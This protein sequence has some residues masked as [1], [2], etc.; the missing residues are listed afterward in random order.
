MLYCRLKVDQL[1]QADSLV[2]R[3]RLAILQDV[4]YHV[5]SGKIKVLHQGSFTSLWITCYDSIRVY[6]IEADILCCPQG[7]GIHIPSAWGNIFYI[8]ESISG[9][10]F[11]V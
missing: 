11:L 4:F 8:L 10:R 1:H 6:S 5:A 9:K 7:P 2:R 3:Q